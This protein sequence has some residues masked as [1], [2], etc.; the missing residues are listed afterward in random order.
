MESNKKEP[1]TFIVEGMHCTTCALSINKT[2]TNKGFEN[3]KVNFASKQVMLSN[4]IGATQQD[5]IA[6][7]SQ[8]GYVAQFPSNP[9]AHTHHEHSSHDHHHTKK[10]TSI[11]R[12]KTVMQRFIIC[13][14]FTI[15]LFVGMSFG[16]SLPYWTQLA[17]AIPVYAIGMD[18][19]FKSA[20][21]SLKRGVANMNLLIVIGVSVAFFYSV[22]ASFFSDNM[23]Q[24]GLFYDVAAATITLVFL[25]NLLEEKA[26]S[27]TQKEI[28]KLAKQQPTKA[29]MIVYN[30]QGQ[31]QLF[32]IESDQLRVG[33]LILIRSGDIVQKDGKILWG[34]CDVNESILTGESEPIQ[35]TI[36]D[37]IIG[38]STL[39]NGNVKVQVTAVGENTV[40]ANIL[41][42][43]QEAQNEKPP[44]QQL[45]DRISQWFVPLII[46]IAIITLLINYFGAHTLF[47]TA[48]LRSIAVL[49]IAC[50]CAMGLAT[51]AAIAVGLARAAKD[52][53]L[54]KNATSLEN[55]KTIRQVAFD[56][57]GTLTTGQFK[58]QELTTIGIT[59]QTA[60]E[61]IFSIEKYS[62][63][64]IAMAI[65]KEWNHMQ[66]TCTWKTVEEQ[67]GSGMKAID[68]QGNEYHC[69]SYTMVKHLTTDNTHQV[70]L[71]K[72]NTLIAWMDIADEIRAESK[73]VIATL[74]RKGIRTVLVSGDTIEK[75]EKVNQILALDEVYAQQTPT[76]KLSVIQKL[77]SILPTAM[78]G[79]GIN[80]AAALAKATIGI[81]IADAS[82][83][84]IQTA[85][86]ILT[87]HGIAM[88]PKALSIGKATYRTIQTNL[89]WAFVYN[90]IAVP[91]AA[92]G[93]LGQYGP[94]WGALIMGLSDVVLVINSL[95]LRWKK[96]G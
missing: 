24:M 25:G 39:L 69:G 60:K 3:V 77:N 9:S 73:E 59:E 18:F 15:P 23:N 65:L 11:F 45:A 10:S 34:S 55:F 89:L 76:D 27:S 49:V 70:Y 93:L 6:I 75:C 38:G 72:N 84:S 43:I 17:L 66:D 67:K 82:Q 12:F 78:I 81:S 22:Y 2:L 57:T 63:H 4:T 87:Q 46:A 64:P 37:T 29:Q 36:S 48:L 32:E 44:I 61:I 41:R 50:P 90:I 52:G 86:V 71:T 51:P 35:K 74:K 14:C 47:S 96:L 20:W 19:F 8:M 88:L 95:G 54:F 92:V 40:I 58:V 33:D 7:I 26:I 21:N 28:E 16:V 91:V 1:I 42:L 13:A 80:D 31:E 83:I 68:T 62:T 56:K 30:E 5:I 85:S 53:I 94:T 79:D